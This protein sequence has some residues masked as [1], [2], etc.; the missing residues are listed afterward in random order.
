MQRIAHW[1]GGGGSGSGSGDDGGGSKRGRGVAG[2]AFRLPPAMQRLPGAASALLAAV[3]ALPS[4]AHVEPDQVF[5]AQ[6]I[7]AEA[8]GG[9]WEVPTPLFRMRAAAWSTKAADGALVQPNC[10][11]A[12]PCGDVVVAVL[13]T[14]VDGSHPDLAGNV[15]GGESFIGGNALVDENGHG[16]HVSG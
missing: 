16:T 5:Y 14:G 6:V 12:G 7:T 3:R 13:D 15:V 10:T 8:R 4:V 9:K 11:R 2:F 1:K